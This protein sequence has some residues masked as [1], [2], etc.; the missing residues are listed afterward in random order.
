LGLQELA[1]LGQQL[2][3]ESDRAP[4]PQQQQHPPLG[5]TGSGSFAANSS[6]PTD[7]LVSAARQHLMSAEVMQL[8]L[9]Q[10]ALL[11]ADYQQLAASYYAHAMLSRLS[12]GFSAAA[13]AAGAS[14][15]VEGRGQCGSAFL[16]RQPTELLLHQVQQLQRQYQQLLM[17]ST[18]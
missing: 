1:A 18:P 15:A 8:R 9:P 12:E 5:T 6:I 7:V 14:Q 4:W 2:L 11:L 13:A 16:Q 3:L 10:V 17:Q